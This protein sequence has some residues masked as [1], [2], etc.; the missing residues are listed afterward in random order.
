M[1][2]DA[3]ARRESAQAEVEKLRTVRTGVAGSDEAMILALET[4]EEALRDEEEA[5]FR[6]ADLQEL[7]YTAECTRCSTPPRARRAPL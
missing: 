1:L 3:V 7:A 2:K 6:L 5:R 4:W